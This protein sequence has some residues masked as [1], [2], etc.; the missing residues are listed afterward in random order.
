MV[1]IAVGR[2]VV[3]GIAAVAVI[4]IVVDILLLVDAFVQNANAAAAASGE[5]EG[6]SSSCSSSASSSLL[7]LL[8]HTNTPLHKVW[9]WM[10]QESQHT[11]NEWCR[12]Y[13]DQVLSIVNFSPFFVQ[14]QPNPIESNEDV[15]NYSHSR[16]PPC[17]P[18]R[19][20]GRTQAPRE[21]P[22]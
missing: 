3:V 21:P 14:L 19:T 7:L 10:C 12:S 9:T 5:E 18:A 1:E 8:H 17:A 13:R 16:N 4:G 2:T 11:D 6:A 20:H 15:L 22:N